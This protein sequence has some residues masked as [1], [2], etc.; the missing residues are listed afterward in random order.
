M[1]YYLNKTTLANGWMPTPHP[2]D[3]NPYS[4]YG[5]LYRKSIG[6]YVT[7]PELISP[8]LLDCVKRLNLVIVFTMKPAILDGIIKGLSRTQTELRFTDGSQ[9]QV[10]ESLDT[11]QAVNVKK[12]QYAALVRQERMLLVWHDDL[13]QVVPTATRLEEK[14]LSLVWGGG[15][16]FGRLGG[17]TSRTPSMYSTGTSVLKGVGEKGTPLGPPPGTPGGGMTGPLGASQGNE[18]SEALEKDESVDAPESLARPVMRT[19]AMFVGMGMTLAIV[20]L[21]G[22]FISELLIE[23]TVDGT[24]TRLGLIVCVPFL[25]FVSTFFFNVIFTNIFQ[26]VGPIGGQ[27][28]N[29]RF[30]SCIKPSMRRAYQDGFTAPHITIQMPV[31]KEG[32]ESVIIPTVRSLQAAIS[33]YESHGGSA[34]IFINDDGLRIISEEEAQK[35]IDFYH[36]NQIGWVSRPKHGQDGFIRKGKFKKASNMNFALNISQKVEKYM[37]EM[38]DARQQQGGSDMIDEQEEHDLY[39]MALKR[40]LEENP[41][42]QADGNIRMGEYILIVDSDT[43]VPVDCLL[44]GAAEMFLSP[45]VAIVQHSTG[46]MQVSWD[47]FE[48]GITFF[49]NMVY[50]AIRF[51][52]GSGEVAPFVGHNAF[53]RWQGTS[54]SLLTITPYQ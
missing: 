16:P 10:T 22:T 18:S 7:F 27:H 54:P 20:L 45:E 4:E 50:T 23:C 11:M 52:I 38:V 21:F 39:R 3:P 44:Y 13:A 2:H 17:G 1:I 41:L 32:M 48:N 33:F 36:D 12:Y 40:V 53:L 34:S 9:L 14:L 47:Y 49:T 8:A 30:Y 28:T 43:R 24:Y 51:S 25:L 35:R 37:Q 31:Y 29:S 26:I 6:N 15:L 46:V 42:A 19:S 5:V